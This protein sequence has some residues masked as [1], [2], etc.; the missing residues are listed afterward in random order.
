MLASAKETNNN[1]LA[2]IIF[3]ITVCLIVIVGG[4]CDLHLDNLLLSEPIEELLVAGLE[5]AYKTEVVAS[6]LYDLPKP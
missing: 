5:Q 6:Q 3:P 4:I 2:L 1:Y